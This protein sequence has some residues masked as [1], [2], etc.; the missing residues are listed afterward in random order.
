MRT[1]QVA[2]WTG[3]VA[4]QHNIKSRGEHVAVEFTNPDKAGGVLLCIV[5]P[6]NDPTSV[7]DAQLLA[8]LWN[9]VAAGGNNSGVVQSLSE[10]LEINPPLPMGMA[11][12]AHEH[13]AAAGGRI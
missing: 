6:A 11:E 1:A 2:K 10:I 3:L 5:G 4:G 8:K 7:A 13:L 9:E 12:R